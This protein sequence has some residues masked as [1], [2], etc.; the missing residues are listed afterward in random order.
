MVNPL[1][2]NIA[3]PKIA[4]G[5]WSWGTGYRGGDEIFGNHLDEEALYPVFDKATELQLNL[6]DTA[7]VY[8]MNSSET[9]LGN[10]I[11]KSGREKVI[12]ST[13]FTPQLA[14]ENDEEAMESMLDG[15]LKRLDAEFIDIYWIHNPMDI[16]KWTPKLIPLVKKGK[17]KHVGVSNHN[18]TEIKRVISI[19]AEENIPLF[20]VQ[21]HYSLLYRASE[22]AGIMDFCQ[23]NDIKFFSYMVLEQ[24]ALTDKYHK[25]HPLPEGTRRGEAFPPDVLEKIEPLIITM[26]KI[27]QK[28]DAT[29]AQI[30]IAWAIAKQ[31]IPIIGV[32]KVAHIEDAYKASTI[33]LSMDELEQLERAAEVTGIVI[34]GGWENPMA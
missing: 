29:V 34:R 24:G 25:K 20:A 26:K 11:K 21:N 12:I 16:E 7:A 10:F 19:L 17:V 6:W 33:Q 32:T 30:A 4:L 14:K 27:G 9:I 18:L 13:K 5:T 22:Q 15:S 2:N 8:G 23:E 28:K 31:T 1:A 3:L